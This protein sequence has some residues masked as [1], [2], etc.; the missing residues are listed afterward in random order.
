M[1]HHLLAETRQQESE[2]QSVLQ[3]VTDG[4]ETSEFLL[5]ALSREG[6]HRFR[7][8]Q[9][10]CDST[11]PLSFEKLGNDDQLGLESRFYSY[12]P[13]SFNYATDVIGKTQYGQ[14]TCLAPER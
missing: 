4:E 13:M 9:I 3:V 5:R 6:C 14:Q 12:R 10:S 7:E 1:R 2:E 11:S 8:L